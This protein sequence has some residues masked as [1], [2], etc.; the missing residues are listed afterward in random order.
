[1]AEPVL[2]VRRDGDEWFEPSESATPRDAASLF[3]EEGELESGVELEVIRATEAA[4]VDEDYDA[5]E[6]GWPLVPVRG[7]RWRF[8][9]TGGPDGEVEEVTRG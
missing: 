3:A 9:V 8:R 2:Y 5:E 7:D 4:E 1:M 6:H